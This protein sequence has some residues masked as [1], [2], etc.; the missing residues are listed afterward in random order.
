MRASETLLTLTASR[1]FADD[2]EEELADVLVEYLAIPHLGSGG[3][4]LRRRL[5][6]QL[7][8]SRNK[9]SSRGRLRLRAVLGGLDEEVKQRLE[10]A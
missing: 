6:G 4:G 5:A 7:S 8:A 3:D 9:L 10:W 1:H 2:E